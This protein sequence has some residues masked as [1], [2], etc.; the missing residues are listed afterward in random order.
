[1]LALLIYPLFIYLFIFKQSHSMPQAGPKFAAI[2][3]P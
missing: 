1:M 2:F 3:L